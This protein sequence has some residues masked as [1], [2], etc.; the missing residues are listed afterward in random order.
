MQLIK[1]AKHRSDFAV[2]AGT[3]LLQAATMMLR[4]D[5]ASDDEPSNEHPAS[6]Q[7]LF[8]VSGHGTATVVPRQKRR[9]TVELQPGDLLVI[10]RGERHQIKHSGPGALRTISFYAPPAYQADGS[11]R[12]AAGR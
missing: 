8:V 11:L 1:T 10:E 7:W 2:L 9:R 12:R 3:K 5:A 4:G 6:E